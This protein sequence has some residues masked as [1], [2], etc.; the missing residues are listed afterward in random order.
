MKFN[1]FKPENYKDVD[2]KFTLRLPEELHQEVA[3]YS[4]KRNIS[5]NTLILNCIEY[6]VANREDN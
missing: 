3:T 1:I 5:M 2:I 4:N 6:T